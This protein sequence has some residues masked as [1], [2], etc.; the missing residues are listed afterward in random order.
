MNDRREI[1]IVPEGGRY[2]VDGQLCS[3]PSMAI[4][5][6]IHTLTDGEETSP[7]YEHIETD[8]LDELFG[9]PGNNSIEGHLA[10]RY[11]EFRITVESNGV[12]RIVTDTP[13]RE[14]Q[15][16]QSDDLIE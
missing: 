2:N 11:D 10:F 14:R 7:L 15:R 12:I 6:A 13:A 16:N 5:T 4:A 1:E 9:N 3:S 8:A